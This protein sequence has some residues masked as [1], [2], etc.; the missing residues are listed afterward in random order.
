[1]YDS[2]GGVVDG[3]GGSGGGGRRRGFLLGL[4]GPRSGSG[5][6]NTNSAKPKSHPKDPHIPLQPTSYR[7]NGSIGAGG[8][9]SSSP[10][11]RS[12][13]QPGLP[14]CS[15]PS[16]SSPAP[17]PSRW[18]L[19]P[20]L[21][22]SL[23]AVALLQGQLW[24]R[25]RELG[26]LRAEV[27]GAVVEAL[28]ER[29]LQAGRDEVQAQVQAL[30]RA[31]KGELAA[32]AQAWARERERQG[33]G[34]SRTT[35]AA[36]AA[37]AADGAAGSAAAVVAASAAPPPPPL[38]VH[39][40]PRLILRT[41]CQ[42]AAAVTLAGGG[43][44]APVAAAAAAPP[45]PSAGMVAAVRQL[46]SGAGGAAGHDLEQRHHNQQRRQQQ[47][48]WASWWTSGGRLGRWLW[49]LPP[50]GCQTQ[51]HQQRQQQQQQRLEVPAAEL[52]A[53]RGGGP[54]HGSKEGEGGNGD[55]G[56]SGATGGG[57]GGGDRGGGGG[58]IGGGGGGG[59]DRG[60]GGGGGRQEAGGPLVFVGIFT[61][62]NPGGLP[63]ADRKYDYALRRAA[64]RATWLGEHL[65]RGASAG[66]GG[67]G[68][69]GGGG[70]VVVRFVAGEAGGDPAAEAALGREAE[71][72][73]DFLRLP[74]LQECYGCLTN[75]TRA[76][77][78]TALAAFPSV[79]WL[80]KADDDVYLIPHRLPAAAEQWERIGAGYI[81]CMKHGRVIR[82]E[83]D[84]WYEPHHLLLGPSYTMYAYGSAYVLSA[85]AVRNVILKNYHHLRMLRNEDTAVG[86][87]ML[88]HDVVFFEDT[89]LC[90]RECHPSAL[91]VVESYCAG[92][93]AP[94]E[95]MLTVHRND[96][97]RTPHASPLPYTPAHP[98]H[99]AF[100]R[101]WV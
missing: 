11:S 75:K 27:G 59:G 57:G 86:A 30:I 8:S 64:V 14:P 5:D 58:G 79:R 92:L 83:S 4:W 38:T 91:V 25:T 29:E 48:G 52:A 100:D 62:H 65:R 90:S 101:L 19:W 51:Q 43:P 28:R 31:V 61:T 7:D 3:G 22:T 96:A 44:A 97:C 89:R 12:G 68:G 13:G 80:V 20:L 35:A 77:F 94:V 24:V 60:G 49:P 73:G 40:P 87:W 1:M 18:R 37:V 42:S 95:D 85:E 82:E 9:P 33:R 72:H 36:A 70:E 6:T 98:D 56:W 26:D 46:C 78:A 71:A 34:D 81:G 54:R 74:G 93:C 10:S 63:A 99:A 53:L 47:D 17:L 88:A 16:P 67:E 55:G 21:V 66:N 45:P 2:D 76:F 39:L 50:R 23:L 69:G 41:F 15:S 32:A 84:R